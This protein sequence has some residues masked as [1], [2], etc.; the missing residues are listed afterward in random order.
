MHRKS[1][2]ISTFL[3]AAAKALAGEGAEPV[4]AHGRE[5]ACSP[6]LWGWPPW[7]AR[8]ALPPP[9][10]APGRSGLSRRRKA[11]HPH[12]TPH[13]VGCWGPAPL[14]GRRALLRPLWDRARWGQDGHPSLGQ[15]MHSQLLPMHLLQPCPTSL[16]QG[17]QVME[18]SGGVSTAFPWLCYPLRKCC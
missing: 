7:P 9:G 2:R 6:L 11:Q 16:C 18:L 5:V 1:V 17:L 8:T 3:T 10:P 14:A 13:G 15:L 12:Q 4:G